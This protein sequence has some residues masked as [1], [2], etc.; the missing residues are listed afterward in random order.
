[1]KK[2]LKIFN[3]ILILVIFFYTGCFSFKSFAKN[4]QVPAVKETTLKKSLQTKA[5][6]K[7]IPEKNAYALTHMDKTGNKY[8]FL[9][10]FAAMFGVLISSLAIFIGLKLYKKYVLKNNKELDNI[11]YDKTLESPKDFKDA[12]NLFLDKTDK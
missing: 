5:V 8:N 6:P 11:D 1:M 4:T 9:K 12:I 7:S 10:F 2:K 3:L